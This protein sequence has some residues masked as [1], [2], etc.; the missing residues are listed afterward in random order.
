MERSWIYR[1]ITYTL[2][3]V[4]AVVVLI[5]SAAEWTHRSEQLPP[6]YKKAFSRKI[7]LGL[8]LQGGLHLVYE[9]QWEKAVSDKADRLASQI[10][11]DLTKNK[12][13]KG[14]K[15]EHIGAGADSQLVLRFS[16]KGDMRKV[17]NSFSRK[18]AKDLT[19]D[20]R[21]L[22]KGEIVFKMDADAVAETR[23]YAIQ[24]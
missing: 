8:D 16:D 4:A 18:Y 10:E 24:Q 1:V 2:I 14:V 13:V 7:A 17:D 3:T 6:W 11:E 9:V 20:S 22:N 12:R 5:P 15:V 21:D 19:E 23:D